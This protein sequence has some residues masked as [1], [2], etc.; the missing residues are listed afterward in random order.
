MSYM[1][2]NG[3]FSHTGLKADFTLGGGV[4]LMVGIPSLGSTV[5][6]GILRMLQDCWTRTPIPSN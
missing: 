2:T 6:Y 5:V 4:G 1:F 3:P